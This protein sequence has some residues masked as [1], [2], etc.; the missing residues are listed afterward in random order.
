MNLDNLENLK[1]SQNI[2]IIKFDIEKFSI[3]LRLV[4]DS[5]ETI[6]LLS[7]WRDEYCHAFHSKFEVTYEKTKL[8]IH[9]FLTDMDKVLFSCRFHWF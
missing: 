6:S 5:D 8:W 9:S 3:S 4:D 1:N 2:D 7:K